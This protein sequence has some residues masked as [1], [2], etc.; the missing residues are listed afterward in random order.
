MTRPMHLPQKV[1]STK[2]S[3]C[4]QPGWP[5]A[6]Q[7]AQTTGSSANVPQPAQVARIV[8]S[9][10]LKVVGLITLATV[11]SL[12]CSGG[13]IINVVVGVVASCSGW[14]G[15]LRSVAIIGRAARAAFSVSTATSKAPRAAM[16]ANVRQGS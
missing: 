5:T 4:R 3:M 7:L 11:L 10:P 6:P 8:L 13:L 1:C 9:T 15:V 14:S 12:P 16:I 2:I